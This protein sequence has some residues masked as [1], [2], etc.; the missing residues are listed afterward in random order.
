MANVLNTVA[1]RLV[2]VALLIHAVLLPLLMNGV[3]YVVREEQRGD[4]RQS[5]TDL[6]SLPS[7]T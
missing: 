7:P 4:L 2:L 5:R 6:R 3:L 1:G